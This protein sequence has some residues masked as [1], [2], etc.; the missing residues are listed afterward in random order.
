VAEPHV[1]ILG[2]PPQPLA[3]ALSA[4]ETVLATGATYGFHGPK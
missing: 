1:G 4:A 2:D 3:N